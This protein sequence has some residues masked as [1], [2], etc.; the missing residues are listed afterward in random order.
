MFSG[1]YLVAKKSVNFLLL[2]IIIITVSHS[3]AVS[4]EE[5]SQEGT[6]FGHV[7]D[8][9]TKQPIS[10]AFVYCQDAKCSKPTT[11]STGYYAIEHCFSPLTTYAIHC[12][13]HGYKTATK[14]VTTDQD[15]KAI[16][17]FELEFEGGSYS[18][19]FS[20][21]GDLK[22]D[23]YILNSA[24]DYANVSID[25]KNAA[26]YEYRYKTYSDEIRC[27][28]GL[29]L[30]VEN[31]DK[32][33]CSGYAKNR[34]NIPTEIKAF[35]NNVNLA[36]NNSVIASN[37]GIEASQNIINASGDSIDAR[38][39]AVGDDNLN[40]ATN[41]TANVFESFQSTQRI[42]IGIDTLI[43]ASINAI[44]GPIKAISHIWT[45]DRKLESN[46][47][48]SAGIVSIYQLTNPLE[49]HQDSAGITGS[50]SFD[51]ETTNAGRKWLGVNTQVGSGNINSLS[52]I[53]TWKDVSY[54]VDYE[55]MPV[56][57]QTGTYDVNLNSSKIE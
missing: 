19:K 49:A 7:H 54:K 1:G 22:R 28:A 21:S 11:N 6:I 24:N 45:K 30:Y 35:F 16:V 17:D 12:S 48:V 50:A 37:Q 42:A 44:S 52:Q 40:L 5:S 18:E 2:M 34:T 53:A 57:Y 8:L 46:A 55:Y 26:Y 51:T 38:V 3:L 32:I 31:A 36:Y 43:D 56:S 47:D 33:T 39:L 20:G 10:Q 23:Y 25:I 9:D 29:D 15:G 27:I 14:S 4:D 13:K 41:I